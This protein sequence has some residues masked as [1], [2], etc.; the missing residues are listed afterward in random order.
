MLGNKF[1]CIETTYLGNNHLELYLISNHKY[2]Q[3]SYWPKKHVK[4]RINT[5]YLLVFM[6]SVSYNEF[7]RVFL[8]CYTWKHILK[9][10]F[11]FLIF[12]FFCSINMY[13]FKTLCELN[14]KLGFVQDWVLKYSKRFT[15]KQCKLYIYMIKSIS[16]IRLTNDRVRFVV[17]FI[18]FRLPKLNI[19]HIN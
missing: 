13:V 14:I 16:Y 18:F 6:S 4:D 3:A 7:C 1:P 5:E 9:A 10:Y 17:N 8:A 12:I 19:M 11:R 2:V 15:L